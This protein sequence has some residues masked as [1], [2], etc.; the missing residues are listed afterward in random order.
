M[1]LNFRWK[2]EPDGYEQTMLV[3][4]T[5]WDRRRLCLKRL[6]HYNFCYVHSLEQLSFQLIKILIPF[7]P[8]K[9]AASYLTCKSYAKVLCILIIIPVPN[10]LPRYSPYSFLWGICQGCRLLFKVFLPSHNEVVYEY[11]LELRIL[12]GYSLSELEPTNI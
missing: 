5:G 10:G 7:I 11:V 8:L 3:W 6:P 4:H 9:D 12:L 2:E 1:F